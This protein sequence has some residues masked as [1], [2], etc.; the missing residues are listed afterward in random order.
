MKSFFSKNSTALSI[1]FAWYIVLALNL[2]LTVSKQQLAKTFNPSVED[3][4]SLFKVHNI[5]Q[6]LI[7][8]FCYFLIKRVIALVS[9]KPCLGMRDWALYS[10]P[11]ILFSSFMIVGFSFK[12]TGSAT[13]I[14]FSKYQLFKSLFA[15]SGYFIL[16]LCLVIV[17]FDKLDKILLF[18]TEPASTNS[19]WNYFYSHPFIISYLILFACYI[20]YIVISYPALFMGDTPWQIIQ[21]YNL[22]LVN[23]HPVF[24]TLLIHIFIVLGKL[25]HSYNFGIFLF[26]FFQ[27]NLLIFV[28]SFL[29][30]MI[31]PLCAVVVVVCILYERENCNSFIERRLS[32]I[33]SHTLDIYVLHYFIVS[34]V[35]LSL[36]D[37]WLEK[38]GNVF[39]SVLI[40]L[41]LSVIITFV[42]IYIGKILHKSKFIEVVTFGRID[43]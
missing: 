28:E 14:I 26:A 13:C 34:N 19:H 36:L 24:H 43:K 12:T 18:A 25:I 22:K 31:I 16:F 11:A 10:V 30:H 35:K 38:N 27:L 5:D 42:S 4:L 39:L 8:L 21:G 29:I 3:F 23:H 41:F 2:N 15:G 33:G 37:D 32:Y 1:F 6:L 40:T 9:A 17:L 20:P 7:F